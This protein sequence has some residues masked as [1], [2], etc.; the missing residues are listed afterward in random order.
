MTASGRSIRPQEGRLSVAQPDVEESGRGPACRRRAPEAGVLSAASG[1]QPATASGSARPAGNSDHLPRGSVTSSRCGPGRPGIINHPG[2]HYSELITRRR[3]RVMMSEQL[4]WPLSANDSSA[5]VLSAADRRQDMADIN[6]D[7]LAPVDY[8]VV[9]FSADKANFSGEMA[10]ELKAPIDSSTI[11]MLDL[12]MIM[13]GEDGSVEASELRC[14]RQR[15]RRVARARARPGDSARRRGR[16][17]NRRIA[18][19]WQCGRGAGLGEHVGGAVR[20]CGAQIGRGTAD[21]RPDPDPSA[22]RRGRSRPASR[23]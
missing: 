20:L 13:K 11:R 4:S 18:G 14:R 2:E 6:V 12:V 10:L 23:N 5:R 1:A 21:P 16:R 3:T 19:A 15:Y 17:R 7:E 9:G 8:L 22:H